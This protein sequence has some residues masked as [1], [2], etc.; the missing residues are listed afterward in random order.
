M[1]LKGQLAVSNYEV[2]ALINR[3]T[4]ETDTKKLITPPYHVELGIFYRD[5]DGTRNF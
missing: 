1:F 4:R 5:M 3:K 2:S